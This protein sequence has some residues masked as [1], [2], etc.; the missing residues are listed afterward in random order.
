MIASIL[1]SFDIGTLLY[2]VLGVVLGVVVGAIPGMT[3]TM[4]IALTLPLTFGMEAVDAI[5]LLVS[6]YVGGVSGSLITAILMRMPGTPAS[7]MTTLD[8]YPMTQQGKAG[9]ALGLAISASFVGGIISWVFLVLLARPLSELAIKFGEFDFF[10]M[11]VMALLLIVIL[12]KGNMIKGLIAGL[13]GVLIALPGVDPIGGNYRFTFG[14]TEL[15][16]GFSL[17]PVLVGLFAGNQILSSILWP[18]NRQKTQQGAN[19]I[20]DMF[21]RKCDVKRHWFN[22][23]RSSVIGTWVGILPGVGANIG[24]AF[25]YAVAKAS[26]KNPDQYG[27]GSE[28]GLVASESANNATVGGALVPLISLGIPG[29]V[30][31]ALLLGGL[32]IHGLQPGPNLFNSNPDFV[33]AIFATV[34]IANVVMLLFM[35][36]TTGYIAKIAQIP[37]KFLLPVLA[38]LCIVGSYA[39]SNS[40]FNVLVM[41]IFSVVGLILERK[42]YSL[43]PLVIGL[44]LAPIAETSYRS[45]TMYTDGEVLPLI[46][47]PVPLVCIAISILM[48]FLMFRMNKN[49]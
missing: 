45:A 15:Q 39:M 42:N 43:A 32:V 16:N 40:W 6:M 9:R 47:T 28:S 3:A 17:L 20:S 48:G 18:E 33:Y 7:V 31:D 25:A 1:V 21:M 35:Y 13:L 24:S 10:A 29:S 12:S 26:S 23:T 4:L 30:V 34:L 41:M 36:M 2:I 46:L 22:I 19:S 8:G 11:V 49:A 5:S 27:K 38:V 14:I 37:Q 44:V